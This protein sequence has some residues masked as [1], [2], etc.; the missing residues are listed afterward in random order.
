MS[1]YMLECYMPDDWDDMAL[2]KAVY[3]KEL[4]SWRIG[5]RF[6]QDPPNPIEIKIRPGYPDNLKELYSA[7]AMVM[8]NSLYEALLECGIG[9]MDKYDCVISNEE[10]GFSTKDYVAVNLLGM[11]KA[12]DI[13]NSNAVDGREDQVVD[14]DFDGVTIDE[15]KAQ[16][17]LMFRLAENTSAIMVHEK[18]KNHLLS[19]GFDML[20]FVEPKDWAG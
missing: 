16:E 1:Y 14:A 19:K 12:A 4:G 6:S 8:T 11:V 2:L 18:V 5:K 9:N 3:F 13:A 10:T 15:N 7:D 20:S 17:A